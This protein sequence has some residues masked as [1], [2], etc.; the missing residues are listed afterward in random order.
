M[1]NGQE[2][3]CQGTNNFALKWRLRGELLLS[4]LSGQFLDEVGEEE[5][6][7]TL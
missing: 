5:V 2:L 6:S 3:G 7:P 4:R 1:A